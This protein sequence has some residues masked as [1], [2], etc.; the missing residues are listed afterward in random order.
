MRI[1]DCGLKE[2]QKR[3]AFQSTFRNPKSAIVKSIVARLDW[4][5]LEV[6]VAAASTLNQFTQRRFS[7]GFG[8]DE[9][10]AGGWR[11]LRPPGQALESEN[12]GIH[13][14]RAQRHLHY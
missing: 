13:F 12:E 7:F 5:L 9:R 8:Y 2:A 4:L 10:I 11:T 6:T 1:S 3:S 14:R